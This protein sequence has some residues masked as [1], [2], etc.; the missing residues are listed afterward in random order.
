[1]PIASTTS[2]ARSSSERPIGMTGG[3]FRSAPAAS[4]DRCPD[5]CRRSRRGDAPV[6]QLHADLVR[7]LDDMMVGDDVTGRIDDHAGAEAALDALADGRQMLSQQRIRRRGSA[8][9][10]VDHA[11][12]VDVDDCRAGAPHRVGERALRLARRRCRR[13]GACWSAPARA[14][15]VPS[16]PG[17]DQQHARRRTAQTDDGPAEQEER[18][19]VGSVGTSGARSA[20]RA[21]SALIDVCIMRNSLEV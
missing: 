16:S 18:R 2:P 10:C 11:R 14:C 6:G 12:R 13:S 20:G 1:M 21:S 3:S 9:R 7:T 4:P 17:R 8:A 19:S 5:P 15:A